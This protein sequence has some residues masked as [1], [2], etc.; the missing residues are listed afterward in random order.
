MWT[1]VFLGLVSAV[2]AS[3]PAPVRSACDP[4][5]YGVSERELVVLPVPLDAG[6]PQRYAFLDGRR[7]VVAAPEALVAC[8]RGAVRVKGGDGAWRD[9]PR[10]PF[11]ETPSRFQSHG[12]ELAGVLIEPVPAA[13][14]KP[15]LAVLVHGSE[16]TA[17]LG[18]A[19]P[20]LLAAQ[21]IAV[22]AYDKRGTGGS[23]G[24]YTQNFELLADDAA[25]A[26]AE[27]RRLAAGRFDRFGFAGFSQGGWV[28]PLA[29]KR[30]GAGFV[31]VGFGL[32][33][34]PL[35]EDEEQVLSELRR[36]GYPPRILVEAREVTRATGEIMASRFTRGYG[37][38]AAVK[39]RLG[40]APWLARIEGEF[41]G[42]ILRTDEA[43]LRRVGCA[44]LDGLN[45]MWRYDNVALMKTLDAPV[46]WVIAADDR[47]AP[48]DVTRDRLL[49]LRGAG[50]PIDVYR[51][52]ATDHGMY[53]FVEGPDGKRTYTRVTEGFFRL[54]GDWIRG[55]VT[56]PYGRAAYL[57]R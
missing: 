27:A 31:V 57:D 30:S 28:A 5:A 17:V 18:N 8:E 53:E 49:A 11:I 56:P 33:L 32:M 39:R 21:G 37:R 34:T 1:S 42:A 16:K 19:Y 51:F 14:E 38:L 46:L 2:A 55:R 13:R 50:K 7:G 29:A 3:L 45:V 41:T 23:Q 4:G 6:G 26:S 20:Y 35:E 9:W 43:T 44:L 36:L 25:A 54:L 10:L 48:S 15:P 22:F 12:T 40:A 52:P 47:E 24:D